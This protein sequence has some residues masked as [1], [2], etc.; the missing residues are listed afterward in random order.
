MF[1]KATQAFSI[2]ARMVGFC[3]MTTTKACKRI[4]VSGWEKAR[5]LD[6][7]WPRVGVNRGAEYHIK[8]GGEPYR[9][10]KYHRGDGV[11]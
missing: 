1:R 10:I 8:R 6:W 7:V 3:F 4:G 11:P 9:A 2:T 5:V